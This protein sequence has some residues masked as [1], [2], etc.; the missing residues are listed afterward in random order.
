MLFILQLGVAPQSP[1]GGKPSWLESLD[2]LANS[3]KG[4]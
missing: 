4:P 1:D 2:V 3:V